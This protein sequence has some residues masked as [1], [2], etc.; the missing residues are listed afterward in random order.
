MVGSQARQSAVIVGAHY[1]SRARSVSSP[2]QR[3]PGADDNASGTAA[4]LEILRVIGQTKTVFRNS[5]MFA[6]F[7]GEEQ[8]L[9]GSEALA[10]EMKG[11]AAAMVNADMIGY[12]RRKSGTVYF[13]RDRVST[14]VQNLGREL[15]SIYMPGIKTDWAVGCCSDG[16]SFYNQ[17]IPTGSVFEARDVENP[18]YH[19]GSDLPDTLSYVHL[20]HNTQAIMALFSTLANIK[21]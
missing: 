4:V 8:G 5:I 12:E 16:E 21:Q 18:N 19:E 13:D 20:R 7:S 9:Y 11:K 17:G 15:V 2:T 6:F 1:D 14:S 10:A 3:A